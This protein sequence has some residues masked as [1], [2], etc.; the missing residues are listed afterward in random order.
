MQIYNLKDKLEYLDEVAHLEYNEWAHDKEKDKDLRLKRKI[1][2]IKNNLEKDDFCKLILLDGNT[3]I[4]F[5]SIFP[6]DCDEYPNL[7]PWYATMY[8][9]S[10]YRGLGYSKILNKAILTEAKKRGYKEIYLKTDLINYY[11]K[12]GATYVTNINDVEKLYKFD[13]KK[14]EAE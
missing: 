9:K 4:G 11:E 2:K 6:S 3:L 10:N 14:V 7:T 1:E 13:L 8:V 12:F 5:I